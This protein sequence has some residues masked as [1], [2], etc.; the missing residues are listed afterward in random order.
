MWVIG[1]GDSCDLFTK[2]DAGRTPASQASIPINSTCK[3]ALK[4]SSCLRDNLLPWSRDRLL[5]R[6]PHLGPATAASASCPLRAGR[7][8][9]RSGSL[10]LD[11]FTSLLLPPRQGAQP[12]VP[13]QIR[14]WTQ[15]RVSDRRTPVPRTSLTPGGAARL[16]L[17][18]ATTVRER[19]ELFVEGRLEAG[20]LAAGRLELP[21]LVR[22]GRAEPVS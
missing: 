3:I 6:A 14:R 1:K 17:L 11:L 15:D 22:P 7:R 9:S 5:E 13:R 10:P 2:N 20:R 4:C 12:C 21:H 18:A 16:R 19:S 8:R